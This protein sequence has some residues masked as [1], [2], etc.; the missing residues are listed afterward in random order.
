M[1]WHVLCN[2]SYSTSI[3]EEK[4]N[5]PETKSYDKVSSDASHLFIGLTVGFV[6]TVLAVFIIGIYS[7]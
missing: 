5:M 3:I 2:Y 4:S 7:L 6:V 1:N